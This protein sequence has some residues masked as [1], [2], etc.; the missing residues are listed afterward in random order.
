MSHPWCCD[1]PRDEA[2]R[3]AEDG[4]TGPLPTLDEAISRAGQFMPPENPKEQKCTERESG[5]RTE[6][7]TLEI[8]HDLDDAGPASGWEWKDIC[9]DWIRVVEEVAPQPSSGWLTNEEREMVQSWEQHYR[10]G[11]HYAQDELHNWFVATKMG[12]LAKVCEGILARLS[13]PLA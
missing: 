8:T 13:P 1:I 11:S 9:Q 6:R 7:V 2:V 3:A 4:R 10:Q 12:K 5:L